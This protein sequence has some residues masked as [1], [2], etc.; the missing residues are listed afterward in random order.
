MAKTALTYSAVDLTTGI[1]TCSSLGVN[2]VAGSWVTPGDGSET[3][4]APIPDWDYGIQ[5]VD[6][7]GIS[8]P[9]VDYGKLPISGVIDSSKL[10]PWPTDTSLQARI[11]AQLNGAGAGQYVFTDLY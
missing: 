10:V 11:K 6:G 3:M 5:V 9:Y 7:L 4:V 1:V 8:V 2:K